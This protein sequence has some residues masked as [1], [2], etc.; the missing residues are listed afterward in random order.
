MK[1]M[2]IC[3][4]KFRSNF[5]ILI[6]LC[7]VMPPQKTTKTVAEPDAAIIKGAVKT[8]KKGRNICE[9]LSE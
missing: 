4:I 8:L 5:D 3:P 7:K 6:D 1:I 2:K 9:K